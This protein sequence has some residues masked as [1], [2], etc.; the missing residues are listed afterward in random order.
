MTIAQQEKK[1]EKT[2]F[3]APSSKVE[4]YLFY[5]YVSLFV[6]QVLSHI[7]SQVL[8]SFTKEDVQLAVNNTRA[9]YITVSR[10]KRNLCTTCETKRIK[11]RWGKRQMSKQSIM[12]FSPEIAYSES[13]PY[14]KNSN[15]KE[16]KVL[17]KERKEK[18]EMAS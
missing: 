5:I 15:K 16:K 10:K 12:P 4:A 1:E 6:S 8:F 7:S 9:P 18:N 2:S 17:N 13:N 14:I 11:K 3:F